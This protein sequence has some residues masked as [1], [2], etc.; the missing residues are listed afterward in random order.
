[1][2]IMFLR[3][4]FVR[5]YAV[6]AT[7]C[8]ESFPHWSS[9]SSR[10]MASVAC[11]DAVDGLDENS[12]QMYELAL[13]FATKEMAPQMMKWDLEQIFPREMLRHAAEL[14]FGA[15]YCS[16][17]YGGTGLGRLDASVIFEAL[18]HGCP[19]TTAYISIHNMCAWMIDTFGSEELRKQWIAPLASMMKFS[20]YCLTEPNSGSDSSSIQTSAV[21]QGDK[22]VLNGTKSFISGAGE[23]DLY[24]VMCRTGAAGPKGISCILVEAD[25]K[26]LTFGKKENKVG[27]LSH[28]ARQ[29]FFDNV[30]VPVSNLLGEE[31]MGFTIAMKGLNGG[32]INVSSVSLGAA[33]AALLAAREYLLER[34]QFGQQLKNFQY[35]QFQLAEMATNLVASRLMVRNAAKALQEGAPN[36]VTQC[37]MAKL[38]ATENCSKICDQAM[39]MFGGYGYLKEF[40][41][42]QY[43][44]D[45]RLH[46][47]IEGTNEIMRLLV[48][49]DLLL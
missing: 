23:S 30:T 10:H 17:D 18:S 42:Q 33:H 11:I 26:G 48:A 25:S 6:L 9:A 40:P 21:R 38:F 35:L 39:Q 41:V 46:H 13:N 45:A 44:R 28:P 37:A 49:R 36:H 15:V 19:S 20:S 43:Y 14:G 7:K 29:V 8:M 22:F 12:K 32:R 3:Q 2:F 31:G 24:L 16:E 47:I 34:K 4:L 5:N 27:W 1:M